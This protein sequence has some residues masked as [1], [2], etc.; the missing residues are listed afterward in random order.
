MI[1][2]Y[3]VFEYYYNIPYKDISQIKLFY[4]KITVKIFTLV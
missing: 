1:V 2:I 3:Y 4:K